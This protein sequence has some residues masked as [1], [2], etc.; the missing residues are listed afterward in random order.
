MCDQARPRTQSTALPAL[1]GRKQYTTLIPCH[2]ATMRKLGTNKFTALSITGEWTV[3]FVARS[4]CRRAA[5]LRCRARRIGAPGSINP[6]RDG[7]LYSAEILIVGI[8]VDME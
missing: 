6:R 8:P 3:D 2:C 4:H 7:L 1:L 5:I